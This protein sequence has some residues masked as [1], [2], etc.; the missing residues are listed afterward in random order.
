MFMP[1]SALF[2]AIAVVLS[3][4]ACGGGPAGGG[5]GSGGMPGGNGGGGNGGSGGDSG[6]TAGAG[7][8][9]TT[10]AGMPPTGSGGAM[11]DGAA[12]DLGPGMTDAPAD[13]SNPGPTRS[14]V[15]A[16]G[17]SAP[18]TIF[19]LNTT[20]GALTPA[21][22][23]STGT[24]GEPTSLAFSPD[25]RFLYAGDEQKDQPM[26]RIIAYTVNQTTGALQ[27]INREG[28]RGATNAHLAVHPS[29]KWLLTA[30]YDTGN[31]TVFAIRDDGGLSP[32]MTPVTAGGQSHYIVFDSTGKF[33]YVP[34]IAAGHVAMFSFADGVLTP[35]NPP[36][37]AVSGGPRHLALSPDERFAYLL[38][39][40]SSTVTTFTHD[41]AIGRLTVLET[42]NTTPGGSV[43]AH[44]AVHPSGKFVYASN[45]SDNSIAI[46][47]VNAATG[48]LARVGFQRDMI[49]YPWWFG[50]D[51]SGQF[52]IVASD[53]SATVLVHRIDQ[54]AGTLTPL[55]APVTVALRP[56]F[57][58]I[59]S[60]P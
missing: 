34:C 25:K 29:G 43:G 27:E 17:Y 36:T 3:L 10:D 53:R 44:I 45:R 40:S 6:G 57:V 12:S 50:I 24:G 58:G 60:L 38:T 51:A 26:S 47:N 41:K 33:V 21:G 2:L 19:T 56:T 23:A 55:G 46:F 18:I 1:R 37:V 15:Y 13:T 16:S 9:G 7:T 32:A 14:F 42:V 30:N 11:P 54:V 20:T 49:S 22:M 35:N 28:T 48:R 8:G 4:G 59:L 31:V 5:G 52:L 39:Q